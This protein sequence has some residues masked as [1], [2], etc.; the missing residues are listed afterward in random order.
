MYKFKKNKYDEV[1]AKFKIKGLA[2]TIGITSTYLSMVL[3]NKI[4]CKKTVAYC[5]T[6]ALNSEAEIDQFFEII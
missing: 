3:N 1:I 5:I 2:E 6:K 4:N